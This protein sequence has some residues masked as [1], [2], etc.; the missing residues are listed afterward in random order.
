MEDL[1]KLLQPC[2]TM[3][4]ENIESKSA[5]VLSHVKPVF[6]SKAVQSGGYTT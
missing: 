2:P 6:K 4:V 3:Q 1:K 5:F